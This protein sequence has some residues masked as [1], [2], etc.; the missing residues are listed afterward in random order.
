LDDSLIRKYLLGE[1]PENEREAVG[2]QAIAD[3][4]FHERVRD[5]ENDLID[6][7]A[8]GELSPSQSRKVESYL[9]AS[10]QTERLRFAR[11]LA[12]RQP[13]RS[14]QWQ[15][16]AAIAA[17]VC[18]ALWAV[19]VAKENRSP[20]PPASPLTS[21]APAPGNT[22]MRFSLRA[23]AVRDATAIQAIQIPPGVQ[24]VQFDVE[25]EEFPRYREI[26]ADLKTTS[27]QRVWTLT[28]PPAT[29]RLLI[30]TDA[31]GAGSY[32]LALTGIDTG[33]KRELIDYY[34]FQVR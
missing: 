7:C 23:G 5:V 26:E 1:L 2:R 14:L 10:G 17:G 34:Y 4:E 31:L 25:Q 16:K 22:I 19:W 8:R 13:S 21:I 18:I 33:G 12:R 11:A 32:E 27:G 30:P 3:P 24:T 29:L 9:E 20:R 28:Q 15:G 6:A